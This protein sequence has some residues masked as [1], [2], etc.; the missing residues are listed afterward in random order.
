MVLWSWAMSGAGF[1]RGGI[2]GATAMWCVLSLVGVASAQTTS[3][4]AGRVADSSGGVLTG[5]TVTAR[6][7]ATGHSRAVVTGADGRYVL[8]LLPVGGYELRAELSGF[9]PLVRK[10]VETTVAVTTV[11]DLT[12][13]VGGVAEEVTVAGST[14]QVNVS[15]SEL[16]YLVSGKALE[17]LPLNGRNYTDLAM[18]QPGVI[19]YA[20]RDGG[21][22]VAH[23]LG[24]S[25]NGQDPRSNVYLLD[26]TLL[27]DFT[28]A[29]AGSAASTAL[30]LETVREFRVETNAYSAEFGRNSGGQ[31][32]VLTKSGT[33]SVHGSAYEF[34]R[35]DAFDARN[36]FDGAS[37]PDFWR[38]QFGATVG[39]PIAQDRLFYFA[40]YEGL[41]EKLGRTVSTF[42]PDD[43]ARQGLLPD[44]ARPGQF[45]NVGVNP[46]VAP[47]LNEYP[48]ANGPNIGQGIAGYTFG[49]D[50]RITEDFAQGR[51]DYNRGPSHQF[52]GRYT[53]DDAEQQLPTDYP[54][55]PRSFLSRNQFFTGEYRW[56]ASASTLHT[57]RLGFSRTRIGQNVEANTSTTLAPFVPG[58][59]VGDIDVANLQR[60][61]PQSSA[62]LR[63]V[64]NVF[65]GQ[66]S[67]VQTRGRH[68]L[69]AGGLV[70]RY[71]MNMVNPTFSL[72]IY[73]F[74]D[75]RA[76][77]ENR[78]LRFVGLTPE[79]QFDRYWRSTLFGVFAQ[80]EFQ[81]SQGLTLNGGVRYETY[82]MPVDIYGRDATLITMADR[83]PTLGR[84]FD[85]PPRANVSPRGGFAWD[86]FG[87]GRTSVRG[88]YG[89][90]FNTQNQQNLIVTVT[91]PPATPRPVIANP[92]FPNPFPR[93][94]SISIRPMQ[95][96]IENPRVHVWNVNVQ[97][98]LW[99]DTV[100]TAGYAGSR[101]THLLRS[102]DVNVAQP[103]TLPDGTPFIPLGTPRP[104]SAFTT[105]ELKS[106]DGDSWYKAFI[107]DVRRRFVGGLA[108]QSSYTLSS[109]ED[110]TQASTF[111]SDATNGTTS[112]FPE[113][114]PGY[115]KGPSDFDARHNWVVNFT[116][117]IPFARNLDGAAKA[118]LDGWQLSGIG[119]L[120]SGNPLT[121]FVAS[122]RSRSQWAPSLGPGIGPD[123]PS[124]APGRGPDDAVL[125]RP[126]QWFDPTAFVLQPAGTFGNTGRGDFDGPDLKTLDLSLLKSTRWSRL[127]DVGRVELRIEAFNVFNHANFSPPN[128]TVF[129]GTDGQ[130]P[131][132]T[133]G[134][135]RSTVT[136]SR[137]IQL[138]LRLVF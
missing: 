121:V 123:R 11:V 61:G 33:N 99:A 57:F 118:L 29:P 84:L 75:L 13:E 68:L 134:R 20:N 36:F 131:L 47:Y 55:F 130:P 42:V 85:H 27:N 41:R 5:V 72:G 104:N 90:Y 96:D 105:I 48:R 30:G 97:R 10:G 40:G 18:L 65:S 17:E 80:D 2:V 136:S 89:L 16:S 7:V 107:L 3:T 14:Q 54:Q 1:W 45:V 64:Q 74:S 4:I 83:E 49:F 12:L 8:P 78:P 113:F 67:V 127:G 60:F 21:S 59:L 76:F 15:S 63:L 56:I 79:A 86:P 69:K 62:N 94:G 82:T 120:R 108:L 128:L 112:A 100:V 28:N 119:Q 22:V 81:V 73:T 101:G 129:S 125:G 25:I 23:G 87:D 91:N 58:R 133:F 19:P 51:I 132:S 95:W 66:Y 38:N 114:I 9:K 103:T 32:N 138:G 88:G 52:F 39:G 70:E 115:N 117:E 102:G 111:F 116:W 122:N 71:Q 46:A 106:S 35:N 98:E 37:Q 126:D 124:Y 26:G 31:V 44:P 110:T 6:H 137:Q 92:T 43:N 50:Q 77:L 93:P 109:S 135:V 34:H 24:M 53:Y